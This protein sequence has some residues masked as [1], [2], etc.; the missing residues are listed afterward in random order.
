VIKKLPWFEIILVI[1]VMSMSVYAALSDAQNFSLRWF[2]RD[3]AYYYFKVAQN[4]SEGHGSTFDGINK[5]NGYHPLWM[6][7]CVPIFALARF[8]LVLPLRILLLVMSALQVSTAIIL[9]RLLGKV[10]AP[11]IGAIAALFWVFS[12]EVLVNIYQQ[13][14]ESGI[15]AFFVVLLVYK[16]YEFEGLWRRS[17]VSTKQLASLGLIAA[18]TVFSRLDLVF[19]VGMAGL[20]IV[21]RGHL[22][23]YLLPLDILATAVSVFLSFLLRLDLPQFYDYSKVALIMVALA[24][25]I[26]IIAAYFFGLYQRKIGTDFRYFLLRLTA[27]TLTTSAI[28]G[29][30]TIV[31]SQFG[32][33]AG[34]PRSVIL[35]DFAFT[36]LFFGL[37]RLIRA[38]FQA[39]SST[40]KLEASPLLELRANSKTW[41]RDGLAYFGV[42]YGALSMYMFWSKFAFGTFSPVSGQIKRWWGSFPARVYGGATRSPLEFFG[43]DFQGEGLA[44]TP[45]ANTIGRW[46][47]EGTRMTV[48][49]EQRYIMFLI[50]LLM[51][52]LLLLL[53]NKNKSKMAA[54]Q[55]SLIPLFCASIL[56]TIYYHSSGYSAFKEWY[57]VTQRITAVILLC[58]MIGVLFTLTRKIPYRQYIAWALALW[59][60][61]SMAQ[62]YWAGIRNVMRYNRWSAETP[63]MEIATLLEANTE[64]GSLIGFTGGGNVG[65]FIQG[66]TIVNMDGLIN[67]YDYFKALQAGTADQYLQNIGLDYVLAN[68]TILD[69]QPYDGQFDEYLEATNVAY[70]GKQLLRYKKP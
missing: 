35:W 36:F 43:I 10:F 17:E 61:F 40:S 49:T 65:Y 66:R 12:F 23:R 33:Y 59:F 27:F 31:I 39:P 6:A 11:A 64:P 46:A 45:I 2:T 62:E 29:I 18:L 30:V 34:F 14:L 57:W 13:G 7:I 16:L 70:G 69:H 15:A 24:L 60:G 55:L 56:Q 44:W 53:L 41:I 42:A 21:F 19:L 8:D 5:T 22:L 58:M 32:D 1:A 3:D 63:M 37:S 26:K 52:A 9:Y 4:I 20:W 51:P 54:T 50:V 67:S 47:Q 48:E 38:I 25:G 68:P 28:L